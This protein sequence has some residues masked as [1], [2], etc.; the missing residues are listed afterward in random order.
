MDHKSGK[1]D[2][3]R[4]TAESQEIVARQRRVSG[5]VVCGRVDHGFLPFGASALIGLLPLVTFC[6]ALNRKAIAAI[7]FDHGQGPSTATTLRKIGITSG[8]KIAH[9]STAS[10]AL[11]ARLAP[12]CA[13]RRLL[14]N[15]SNAISG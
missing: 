11:V 15:T 10:A 5:N 8:R 3:E 12:K 6:N 1:P 13:S 9:P 7:G 14:T 2:Q 4:S